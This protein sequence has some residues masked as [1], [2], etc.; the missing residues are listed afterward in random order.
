QPDAARRFMLAYVRGVREYLDAFFKDGPNRAAVIEMMA[1]RTS[2]KD[3]DM[4]ERMAAYWA[5]PD[6][7]INLQTVAFDQ[8]RYHDHGFV[9]RPVDLGVVVDPSFSDWAVAQIGRAP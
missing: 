9:E 3:V 7:A 1:R 4:W 6:G 2:I 8:D 5:N